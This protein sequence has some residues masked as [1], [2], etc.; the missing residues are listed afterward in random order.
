VDRFAAFSQPDVP[1][2]PKTLLAVKKRF[3]KKH[4]S[5]FTN[6]FFPLTRFVK[7]VSSSFQNHNHSMHWVRKI[8][9]EKS[10]N[11]VIL[12]NLF[13]RPMLMFNEH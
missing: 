8:M 9:Q 2:D 7:L 13:N 12:L 5:T 6:L 11:K 10:E 3:K 1:A 4:P